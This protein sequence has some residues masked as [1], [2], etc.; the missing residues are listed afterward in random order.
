MP[1]ALTLESLAEAVATGGIDTV[2]AAQI[3]MQGRLMGKRFHAAHFLETA[4][5]GTHGCNYL[6]ATDLEMATVEGYAATSW[7]QGYGDYVMR[8]DLSTLRRTPWAEGT[9]LVLC[10]T[11]D[12][13]GEH[14]IAHAPRTVLKRQCARLAERGWTANA[15]SEL[16]FFLFRQSFE[17]A[18][19]Q[20]FA[21]LETFSAYNEDYHVLQSFKAEPLMRAVR[22]ALH[23][24]DVPVE[25]TK[26]EADAGQQEL[27]V[28]YADALSMADRHVVAKSAVKEIAWSQGRA[29]TFMAKW[30]DRHAGSSCHV[31]LSLADAAGAPLFPDPAGPDG[32][33]PTMRAF[34][35]GLLAHAGE[36]APFL[37]PYVNSYK[38]FVPGAFAPTR[39][40]W[41]PDNRTAGF[42]VVGGGT[43][44]LRV[45]CRVGGGDLTPH[46]AFAALIAA[47]LAGVERGLELEPAAAGDAYAGAGREIP[48]TL[49]D[50]AAALDRSETM[51]AAFG[52]AVIDHYL[53][54]FA[55]E[56]EV[57][58][59]RVTDLDLKRGFERA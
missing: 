3:D 1:G 45:E 5:R 33:S 15:A 14:E 16:E 17:Q 41:S 54:A 26:G 40:V 46:L 18:E 12:H 22:N 48:R 10:D 49:R 13:H 36:I 35:A 2:V 24:A 58:D 20:G 6:L 7:A 59:A 50:A 4:H 51:R 25:N 9:A 38:R 44:A 56:Q 29:V 31:H 52:D 43:P 39:L 23:G 32:M 57:A 27:N 11:L 34:L 55:W 8:P 19:A 47:G 42:R 30:S 37:A 28:V 21:G 53:R